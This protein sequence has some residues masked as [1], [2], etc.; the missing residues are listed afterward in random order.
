MELR[1][2]NDFVITNELD[3]NKRVGRDGEMEEI[4]TK[5]FA[6]SELVHA[7]D[8]FNPEYFLGEGGF[9]KVFKGQLKDTGQ[10]SINEQV[11]S[12]FSE[13][14]DE[15]LNIKLFLYT[16]FSLMPLFV[17]LLATLHSTFVKC[18]FLISCLEQSFVCL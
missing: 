6:F 11:T 12:I 9:G 16:Y 5:V 4:K 8:N 14:F 10:V 15:V 13:K 17:V 18:F 3:I 2:P 7:T 1:D